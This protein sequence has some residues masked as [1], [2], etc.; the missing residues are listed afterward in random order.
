MH[1][2]LI[3]LPPADLGHH[4]AALEALAAP[5]PATPDA[6]V[7]QLNAIYRAVYDTDLSAFDPNAV[8][9][10][11]A[12]FIMRLFDL[13]TALR[14]R[15]PR[16]HGEG[17]LTR[18]AE[19][20]LRDCF[21]ALRYAGDIIGELAIGFER[22]PHDGETLRAFTGTNCNT[23]VHRDIDTGRPLPFR[24]GDVLLV[25]GM[26]HNSAAIAR[27]GDVD[28][29]FSHV[30]LV[31]VDPDGGHWIIEALIEDG[32]VINPL[33]KT[34]DHGLG[35]AMLFRARDPELAARAAALMYEQ[36]SR[37]HAPGNRRILYDFSM[38]LRNY[39]RLFCAKL[40][41]EAYDKASGGKLQLP[42]FRTHFAQN[43]D[44]YRRI[45]VKA[46]DTFAPGDMEV[47]PHFDFVAE[48]QDYRVTPRLR[49]QDMVMTKMF[50]WMERDNWRFKD[51][52]PVFLIGLFGRLSAHMSERVKDMLVDIIPKIPINMRRRTIATIAML[53]ET[54]EPLLTALEAREAESIAL[55]G[56]PQHPRDVL[57]WLEAQKRNSGGRIGYLTG[58]V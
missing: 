18:A 20:A 31:Y 10:D 25:R 16:Q 51:D 45:G 36:V 12:L 34:L 46:K 11:A 23:L 2:P 8:R 43:R 6:L 37:S 5:E 54:A 7:E 15:I 14:D 24:S 53:H 27:I 40:V 28:S 48:W 52:W 58:P 1:A 39:R 30:G 41:R 26:R 32:A 38:L 49:L 35:R 29:Q 57:A 21:R 3:D 17:L 22:L 47:E 50:E 56:R 33:A 42:T 19:K 4:I 13:R 55:T 9:R 44:F